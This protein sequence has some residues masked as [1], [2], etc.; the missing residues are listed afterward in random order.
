MPAPDLA[1]TLRRLRAAKLEGDRPVTLRTV[2]K[3]TGVSNA[4]LSQLERGEA[5]N[6]SPDKLHTLAEYY[7]VPYETLMREAGYIRER[8]GSEQRDISTFEAQLMS[9]DL[10]PEEQDQVVRFIQHVLRRR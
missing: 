3:K 5:T 10:D 2:S 6:P 4:Y 8:E 1:R 9:M 7:G